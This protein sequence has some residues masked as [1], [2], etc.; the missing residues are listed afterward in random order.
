MVQGWFGSPGAL[1]PVTPYRGSLSESSDRKTSELI[2]FSG[3]RHLQV[4]GGS[5]RSWSVGVAGSPAQL[6]PLKF[7]SST[8]VS[9]V[10]VSPAA[11]A[12]N[13]LT[14]GQ[15][16]MADGQVSYAGGASAR[17]GAL[18]AGDSF[19]TRWAGGP[20]GSDVNV[21]GGK[22]VPVRPGV[23]VTVS[24]W[25]QRAAAGS[26][27]R[28]TYTFRDATGATVG[29][30]TLG[31]PEGTALQRAVWTLTPPAGAADLIIL[32][33]DA[34]TLALP[35]VTWS[36]QAAPWAD[37]R[38]VYRVAVTEWSE[39]QETILTDGTLWVS[40]SMKMLEVG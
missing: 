26:S 29:A 35:Q 36:A 16:M 7:A 15:S 9:W 14:P 3:R 1:V 37:G 40:A 28:L 22:P 31:G 39:D 27:T 4:S 30:S 2:S 24:A 32:I 21:T 19:V 25:T 6:A 8:A 17:S 38:G 23:P 11:Q 20:V 33:R 10:W 18:A 13:L 34:A 5:V 12:S